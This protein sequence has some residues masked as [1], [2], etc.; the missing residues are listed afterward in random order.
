MLLRGTALADATQ[1]ADQ[2]RA[3]VE[4]KKLVK[5]STG[6]VLGTITI[7]IGVAQFSPGELSRPSS[8][9]PTPVCTAPSITAAIWWSTRRCAHGRAGD[10]RSLIFSISALC[11]PPVQAGAFM[12]QTFDRTFLDS[13]GKVAIVTLNH[14]A[15][16]NALSTPWSKA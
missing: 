5:K 1:I 2:I 11:S 14:D 16:I 12:R 9:A 3:I 7:S 10:Q 6:D 4:T 13:D 15:T 8:A